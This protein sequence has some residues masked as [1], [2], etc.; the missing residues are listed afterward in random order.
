MCS[1]EFLIPLLD[2]Y[3]KW[4]PHATIAKESYAMG[5]YKSYNEF[6][7]DS[8]RYIIPNEV[9]CQLSR[10]LYNNEEN[11]YIFGDFQFTGIEINEMGFD[12]EYYKRE[13]IIPIQCDNLR[14]IP[15]E[16]FQKIKMYEPP[17]IKEV[18]EY[19][20]ISER[21]DNQYSC[22]QCGLHFPSER[23]LQRHERQHRRVVNVEEKTTYTLKV[24]DGE[25]ELN[26]KEYEAVTHF[27]K[28]TESLHKKTV[29]LYIPTLVKMWDEK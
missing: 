23:Q 4:T 6:K 16:H 29:E 5:F 27:L 3:D 12:G 10:N 15:P 9:I 18:V 22:A 21:K 26:K 14:L 20:V 1:V 25:I 24:V 17:A 11:D 8:Q 7:K 13:D 19:E 28:G 2:K